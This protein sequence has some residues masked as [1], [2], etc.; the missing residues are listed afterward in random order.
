M[1]LFCSISIFTLRS[2]LELAYF[3]FLR[4]KAAKGAP[5]GV[6][7]GVKTDEMGP[8]TRVNIWANSPPPGGGEEISFPKTKT[9][10]KLSWT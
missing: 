10:K 6:R 9:G 5:I 2:A 8:V 1:H 7:D 3:T 4:L